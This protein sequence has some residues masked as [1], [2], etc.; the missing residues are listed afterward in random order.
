[1]AALFA[2]AA[3]TGS[4]NVTTPATPQDTQGNPGRAAALVTGS[5]DSDIMALSPL[6]FYKLDEASGTAVLDSSGNG[7]NLTNATPASI[8]LGV[9][10]IAG[11]G[12][13]AYNLTAAASTIRGAVGAT[14]V[15]H[16]SM[17]IVA[18]VKGTFSS[19]SGNVIACITE[20]ECLA[21]YAGHMGYW[22]LAPG[23]H[24]RSFPT[25]STTISDGVKH[26]LV[27]EMTGSGSCLGSVDGSPLTSFSTSCG[28][29]AEPANFE[30][31]ADIYSTGGVGT[32]AFIGTYD[33]VAAFYG[34]HAGLTQ[35]QVCQLASDAGIAVATCP[36]PS[37][38]PT[39]SATPTVGPTPN[40]SLYVGNN[41]DG[42]FVGFTAGSY[43]A[44]ATTVTTLDGLSTSNEV[45]VDASGNIWIADQSTIY[46]F[47]S[48][49]N[50]LAPPTRTITLAS[51]PVGFPGFGTV[52]IDGSGT[53]YATQADGSAVFAFSSTAS[54]SSTPARTIAGSATTLVGANLLATD[55][56]G[57][58]WVGDATS[59]SLVEF[60]STANGNAAPTEMLYD[61]SE[62]SACA[63]PLSAPEGLVIDASGNIVLKLGL[64]AT[65]SI[66]NLVE[67]GSGSQAS[68]DCPSNRGNL[69]YGQGEIGVDGTGFLYV[70]DPSSKV[71]IYSLA[72]VY[73]A[74]PS[75][76]AADY[77]TIS[78]GGSGLNNPYSLTVVP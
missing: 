7:Y 65:P 78:G 46:E 59:E 66:P 55:A 17:T 36:T 48:G 12:G 33:D 41:D 20:T 5:L 60:A 73:A 50:G 52:V 8:T 3:C 75:T 62:A 22:H 13:T 18:F 29:V 27:L 68:G 16:T 54:G 35:T 63:L 24:S 76:Y 49:S 9:A 10:G 25:S 47:A 77:E 69:Q 19:L 42:S 45:R 14:V 23:G 37:P 61:S 40:G 67:Y 6:A 71:Y 2:L 21:A 34:T 28:I 58:L 15:A 72:A 30:I 32:P 38:S 53:I 4:G 74:F 39:P 64:A 44:P 57:N 43:I 56:A 11:D 26:M 1:M 70:P 51:P 31:G